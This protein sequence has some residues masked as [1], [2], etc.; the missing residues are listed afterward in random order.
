MDNPLNVILNFVN[1][2]SSRVKDVKINREGC[3]LLANLS[4]QTVVVLEPFDG[5]QLDPSLATALM[6]LTDALKEAQTALERCCD[7]S[8][9][10]GMVYREKYTLSLKQASTKLG[11]ALAQISLM[12]IGMNDDTQSRLNELSIQ[13]QNAKFEESKPISHEVTMLRDQLNQMFIQSQS[14]Q[15]KAEVN[16]L[17]WNLIQQHLSNNKELKTEIE[18]LKEE[19]FAAS[20]N[21]EKQLEFE[22]NVIVHT[23]SESLQGGYGKP[24]FFPNNPKT[25]KERTSLHIAAKNN[26]IDIAKELIAH[27]ANIDLR[28]DDGWTPLHVAAEKNSLDVAKELI[29]H[30]ANIDLQEYTIGASPFSIAIQMNSTDIIKEFIA[31]GANIDLPNTLDGLSPLHIVAQKNS[32]DIAKELIIHGANIDLQSK[33]GASP[34]YVA[35][36]NKSID[37]IKELITEGANIDLQKNDGWTPLHIATLQNS[38]DIVKELVAYGANTNLQRNDG[39]TPMHVASSCGFVGIVKVLL[40]NGASKKIK[41]KNKKNPYDV[42]CSDT[43]YGPYPN[44]VIQELKSLLKL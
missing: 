11:D 31:C 13:I 4:E 44:A 27:G 30:G 10:F 39:C 6:F 1:S 22:L 36:Q 12:A 35:T 33:N 18:L 8:F 20:C 24:S 40:E 23:L 19:A 43:L 21:K 41:N 42:I 26:W 29:A 25:N 15:G 34:L 7:V 17:I 28:E 38:I 3:K 5:N 9:L 37:M 2:I 14:C 32:I 16:Q